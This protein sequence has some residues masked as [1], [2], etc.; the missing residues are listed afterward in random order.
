MR[1]ARLSNESRE[2]CTDMS[3]SHAVTKKTLSFLSDKI[4]ARTVQLETVRRREIAR[5]RKEHASMQTKVRELFIATKCIQ[6][7]ADDL[8]R[9][10][11]RKR[12]VEDEKERLRKLRE[13]IRNE[14]EAQELKSHK[15]FLHQLE[16]TKKDGDQ[17]RTQR[18]K[19]EQELRKSI[20]VNEQHNKA[21]ANAQRERKKDRSLRNEME[22]QRKN[23]VLAETREQKR[24]GL[25]NNIHDLEK[26]LAQKEKEEAVCIQRLQN[27]S[28]IR[29]EIFG[30][31]GSVRESIGAQAIET[32]RR[33]GYLKRF[34][35]PPRHVDSSWSQKLTPRN[36]KTQAC[37]ISFPA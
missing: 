2:S 1:S 3:K 16:C 35:P 7:R 29:D 22:R 20:D 36:W 13:R 31:R 24:I 9:L 17:A 25:L 28:R 10:E 19:R 33:P 18:E 11:A 4:R 27:S 6:S 15:A 8:S 26:I 32:P 30:W 37:P 34:A 5:T 12:I 14:T 21:L 23:Q